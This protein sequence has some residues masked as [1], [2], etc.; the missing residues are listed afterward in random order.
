MDNAPDV[1]SPAKLGPITLRNRVIKAATFEGRTP[2]A[3]VT[4]DL[5]AFHRT[6]AAGG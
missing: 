4:D 3:L 1:F 5:I 6:I 2:D